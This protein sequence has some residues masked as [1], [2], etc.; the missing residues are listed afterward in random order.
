MTWL[1]GISKACGKLDLSI[2]DEDSDFCQELRN[3]SRQDQP[4][5]ILPRADLAD[6]FEQSQQDALQSQPDIGDSAFGTGLQSV[7]GGSGYENRSV[8]SW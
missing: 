5:Q 2:T 4:R 6:C 3:S 7:P 8:M 1:G